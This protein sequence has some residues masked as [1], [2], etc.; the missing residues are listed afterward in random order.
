[1]SMLPRMS[2]MIKHRAPVDPALMRRQV[3]LSHVKH[4]TILLTSVRRIRKVTPPTDHSPLLLALPARS[5]L[6]PC[7]LRTYDLNMRPIPFIP[8][9]TSFLALSLPFAAAI[10][11]VPPLILTYTPLPRAD[12][13]LLAPRL[14]IPPAGFLEK[15]G[16]SRWIFGNFKTNDGVCKEA[17]KC[18]LWETLM[19]NGHARPWCLTWEGGNVDDFPR[20]VVL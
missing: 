7:I 5:F 18:E 9:F 2:P 17:G 11:S 13:P 12:Q 15:R 1:M 10:S 16:E 6:L 8:T 3:A 14:E 4:H 20:S 19:G